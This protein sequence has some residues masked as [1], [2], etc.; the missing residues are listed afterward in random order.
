M[1]G[2]PILNQ[3]LDARISDI[4]ARIAKLAFPHDLASETRIGELQV[5]IYDNQPLN[6]WIRSNA[7]FPIV[8]FGDVIYINIDVNYNTTANQEIELRYYPESPTNPTEYFSLFISALQLGSTS[9]TYTDEADI[10]AFKE[11][12]Q[13]TFGRLEIWTKRTGSTTGTNGVTGSLSGGAPR[14]L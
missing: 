12:L 8:L 10:T 1:R 9:P 5:D 2:Y 3:S 14:Y 4:E 13:G 6:Q 7:V 11:A